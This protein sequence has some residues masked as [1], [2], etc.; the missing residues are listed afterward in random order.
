[1]LTTI[2][3]RSSSS[4]RSFKIETSS[5]KKSSLSWSWIECSLL[6]LNWKRYTKNM[7]IRTSLSSLWECEEDQPSSTSMFFFAKLRNFRS[8]HF[9][10][11]FRWR[12]V[13][14]LLPWIGTSLAPFVSKNT[15]LRPRCHLMWWLAYTELLI[16]NVCI[17]FKEPERSGLYIF[18][19]I[20]FLTSSLFNFK[21]PERSGTLF[22]YFLKLNRCWSIEG[23]VLILRSCWVPC[24]VSHAWALVQ[25]LQ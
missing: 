9:F 1:M 5:S 12:L 18:L 8:L 21:V 22:Y 14:L 19:F 24:P 3:R 11:E 2:P 4:S 17:K 10:S 25:S 13:V 15:R 16:E 6:S 23:H 7:W 20:M